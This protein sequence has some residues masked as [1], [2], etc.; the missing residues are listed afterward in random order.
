MVSW[1]SEGAVKNAS[2]TGFRVQKQV[3]VEAAQR[4]HT[5]EEESQA[6]GKVAVEVEV[7]GSKA[8]E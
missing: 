6:P 8:E 1:G 7:A 4:A 5:E 3:G 2:K